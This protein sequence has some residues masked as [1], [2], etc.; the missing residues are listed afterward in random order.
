[1]RYLLLTISLFL[2]LGL[3]AQLSNNGALI[4]VKSGAMISVHEDVVNYNGGEF[5]NTDTIYA[6]HDWINNAGN[7]AFISIGVGI[8]HLYGDDQRITGTDITRFYD[9]RLE[10]TGVKYGDLDVYVDG[11]LRLNDRRFHL[12]TNCVTV[13]NSDLLSVE[14]VGNGYVSALEAGGLNRY[15]ENTQAYFY[16][17]GWPNYYRP[18]ELTMSSS[19]FNEMK[20]RMAFADAT[21]EGFDRELRESHLC[22]V[23]PVYYHRV[24]QL[25]GND[26][27]KVKL[28]YDPAVDGDWNTIAHFQN[29]PQWED[30]GDESAGIDLVSGLDFFQSIPFITDFTYPAF[31]LGDSSDTLEL[32]A[33]DTIICE[34][35]TVTFTGEA[36][37]ISYEF[38]INGVLVQDGPDNTFITSDIEDGDIVSFTS[39]I[40]GC[41][42]EGSE[43]EMAVHPLPTATADSNSPVCENNNLQLNA[44]GGDEYEWE[45]PNGFTSTE[46]N[47]TINMVG[48]AAMGTYIVTVTDSN[49]CSD[50]ATVDISIFPAP[51]ATIDSNSPLCEG[52]NLNLSAEGGI[53]YEWE[54]PEGFTSNNQSPNIN[55]ITLVQA[56]DYTVTV[57]DNNGC[58]ASETINIVV[59]PLPDAQASSNSPLCIN[60]ILELSATG[61]SIYSWEGPDGFTSNDQ[62]PS[63][64]P[65]G[66]DNAGTYTVTITD[67]N[68]CSSTA[69]T[70]VI[71]NE[72]PTP[73]LS[74][75]SPVCDQSILTLNVVGG[76]TYEWEG[77]DNFV[78]NQQNPII[79]PVSLANAGTYSVTVTDVN[80]CT[81]TGSLDAIVHPLPVPI[82]ISNSPVCELSTLQLSAEGGISYEWEGPEGFTSN[83]QSPN[84]NAI[85]L[86][87]AGDYTVTVTDN[88]GCTASET[89]NIVVLPLPDAQASSNSPLCINDI[90]ELSATGGSIYSWEGPDGFTSNDQ[91]PSIAP[92]GIDNAGTYTVTITDTNGCSSTAQ[93]DVIINELPTPI[94]SSNSPVC[95]Q[96]ILTLNVVGGLTYEWEG[97][98]NFVSNQ[99]NPIIDPV[100]LANAGT[101]SVTVTDVNGCTAT[102]SLDAIV[103]PLPVPIVISNSPV[104]ELSTLQ[105]SA[106][107][108]TSYEWEG[109]DGFASDEQNPSLDNISI[110]QAGIYVVTVTDGN[111]CTQIGQTTVVINPLP[112]PTATNSGAVCLG[113]AIDLSAEGGI[114]YEWSGPNG[115]SSNEQNP[116]LANV[117]AAT[118]GI[119]TVTVTDN[120]GCSAT[121]ET[122][123]SIFGPVDETP[124]NDSPACWGDDIQLTISGEAIWDYAWSGPD[125]FSSTEQNPI[126]EN[127]MI[128]NSGTYFVTIT[129]GNGCK[130]IYSTIVVVSDFPELESENSGPQCE[131]VDIMLQTTYNPSWDYIWESP[132]GYL[133]TIHNPVLENPNTNQSGEYIVT[134]TNGFGCSTSDTVLVEIYEGIMAVSYGDTTITENESTIIGVTGSEDYTYIWNPTT[135]LN[136]SDCQ[137]AIAAPE[138]STIY[139][140]IV[141]NEFGCTDTFNIT[142]FV[143]D[144][145]DDDL[146]VPNTITPNDDGYNDTWVIPWLDRFPDNEVVI[147]NRW[148]DEV[149]SAKPYGNDFDG[150]YNGKDLPAGTYYFI[151]LLGEDFDNFKGPLTILRE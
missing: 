94:L 16:P 87:Q 30:T 40:E 121:A 122:D 24:Y 75:N 18:L 82:V 7:E 142:I 29:I 55:A 47:P 69:Q 151:L 85:T 45:G 138:S 124:N 111:G 144:R 137:E 127:S 98:D 118:A 148:G 48:I 130:G 133:D 59:L 81:A 51:I 15:L 117:I 25:S 77:P 139:E 8:V 20:V 86:V 14:N 104:C 33:S 100:S 9:L 76:L 72:L 60:D 53:S 73:I 28:H 90:L 39:T 38:Y 106:E 32:V 135:G 108:G 116:T 65:V 79:D 3:Y 125:D 96:S 120:N 134:A 102:G 123:V 10:Q 71:I 22:E 23:N 136:C 150:T 62:H 92:V 131:G 109:P 64:A 13:F 52:N 68:G 36:G 31:A 107:G 114:G 54:G 19:S 99:Q 93:T 97:P 27:A 91:H 89:I 140:V 101:Y 141:V 103:H 12:D 78:S 37:Y 6:F 34:G 147:I 132:S 42:F 126:I 149:Y 146:V 105:L 119:Y 57:T 49:S 21:D 1:M 5:H 43:I 26:G 56:G 35:E 41:V 67:T 80:G 61:G 46:Q 145:K 143:E 83:N 95:D 2:T 70:D 11:F 63:I 58:T 44:E 113:G 129:D 74:S 4:S 84:I 66:I 17:V 112:S 50:T 128:E 88:N 110:E 115:Y